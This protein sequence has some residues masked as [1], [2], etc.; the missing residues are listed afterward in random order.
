MFTHILMCF[1]WICMNTLKAVDS[2]F[3]PVFIDHLPI[4]TCV[5]EP[6]EKTSALSSP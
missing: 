3:D 5:E 6:R 2:M 1:V 4:L